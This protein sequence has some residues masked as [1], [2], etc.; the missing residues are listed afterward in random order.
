MFYRF[1]LHRASIEK[2]AGFRHLNEPLRYT[3][4]GVP[5]SSRG[6]WYHMAR[7]TS[8]IKG[9]PQ[10]YCYKWYL[11]HTVTRGY[12]NHTVANCVRQRN[13]ELIRHFYNK[14]LLF[15]CYAFRMNK[16]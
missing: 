6:S 15:W 2:T 16:T 13:F 9:L 11:N 5:Q 12:L 10:P 4:L 14:G 7:S 8:I 3:G 1:V